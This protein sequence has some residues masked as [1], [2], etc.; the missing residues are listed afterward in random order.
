MLEASLPIVVVQISLGHSFDEAVST[1]HFMIMIPPLGQ[2]R[3]D[4]SL[5]FAESFS[6]NS[7]D[8]PVVF[9]PYHQ[10]IIPTM[11]VTEKPYSL[12]SPRVFSTWNIRFKS[13]QLMDQLL[14]VWWY[15]I[16]NLWTQPHKPWFSA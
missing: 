11:R 16:K 2:Y 6:T 12:L 10:L 7:Q 8:Q 14:V 1:D 4:Y 15:D 13:S 9:K 5:I 3:N